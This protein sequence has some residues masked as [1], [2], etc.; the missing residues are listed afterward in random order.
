MENDF[1]AEIKNFIKK[2]SPA[3]RN[4][5]QLS[6]GLLILKNGKVVFKN[7]IAP[8]DFDEKS[9]KIVCYEQ[10]K[11]IDY[12]LK[13]MLKEGISPRYLAE[14]GKSLNTIYAI[15]DNIDNFMQL[16]NEKLNDTLSALSNLSM[17][18]K[19]SDNI[20]MPI[21]FSKKQGNVLNWNLSKGLL[22]IKAENADQEHLDSFLNSII[23]KFLY[24]FPK[25]SSKVM[26]CSL[27]IDDD[28]NLFLTRMKNLTGE[29][30]FYEKTKYFGGNNE[31][32]SSEI[33]DALTRL[34]NLCSE[35]RTFTLSNSLA[36]SAMEY[37]N[38]SP[39]NVIYPIL[40]FLRNYPDGFENCN[41]LEYLFSYARKYGIYFVVVNSSGS[42]MINSTTSLTNPEKYCDLSVEIVGDKLIANDEE[43]L[44]LTIDTETM[45]K[46]FEPLKK[47]KAKNRGIVTYEDVN[48]GKDK[49]EGNEVV[50]EISVPIGKVDDKIFT[51]DFAVAGSDGKPVAYMIIGKPGCGKSSIIDSLI[52]NGSMKYSPDDL[53]F[54][55]IDFKDG[56]S[57]APYIGSAK[58]P[59]IKLVAQKSKQEEA[60][61]IL[62]TVLKEKTRRNN[63][64]IK[65]G[66]QNLVE[67]NKMQDANGQKHLPRI[68][69]SIDEFHAIFN[70]DGDSERT[71]RLSDYCR[72]I[73]KEARSAGIHLVIA[74]QSADRKIMNCVGDFI[75]GRFCFDVA[76]IEHAEAVFNRQNAMKV[77]TECSGKIGVAMVSYD[78][79]ESVKKLRCSYHASKM[80]DFAEKVRERYSTYPIDTVIVGDDSP[81]NFVDVKNEIYNDLTDGAPIGISYYDHKIVSVPFNKNSASLMVSGDDNDIQTDHLLSIMLYALKIKAKILLVDESDSLL[82]N[83]MF[84]ECEN[85][86]S[87]TGKEYLNMLAKANKELKMRIENRRENFQ[88]YFV[89]VH[90]LHMIRDFMEDRKGG[91]GAMAPSDG[92]VSLRAMREQ[93]TSNEEVE[94]QTTF[95]QMLK[96]ASLVNNF[97]ICFSINP[98]MFPRRANGASYVKNK[99]F[100]YVFNPYMENLAEGIYH[101]KKLGANCPSSISLFSESNQPFEKVR[102]FHYNNNDKAKINEILNEN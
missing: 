91:G 30:F 89:I 50:N 74:S 65:C 13:Y 101:H 78:A 2:I 4:L 43:Y 57:S 51:M 10:F 82:L 7:P 72:Q 83:D 9:Y 29:D 61:I 47:I 21:G 99:I 8:F 59:H 76:N 100:H 31:K 54:Y 71:Q 62:K 63:L 93:Q 85:V 44:S 46:L 84:G 88:P 49:L 75:S 3:L 32:Y 94:G 5:I 92:Y 24:S 45:V 28:T 39:D 95:M 17:P 98:D 80:N 55:L 1:V 27:K 14:I 77:K 38:E 52:I 36:N 87:Y 33:A 34:Y 102:F 40:V 79:G 86:E 69:V 96:D 26:Y 37:N 20:L 23:L 25:A 42:L 66:C 22:Y 90:S 56:V 48:F 12:C 58:M 68:I 18:E 11:R 6:D 64:F 35:E 19:Y 16:D 60:E 97:Y 81:L 73:V 53:T 15:L 41:N 67:Y 70:D